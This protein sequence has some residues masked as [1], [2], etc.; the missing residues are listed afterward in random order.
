M[1][2][3]YK[4]IKYGELRLPLKESEDVEAKEEEKKEDE[5]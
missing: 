4:T 5:N 1:K 2:K 3:G